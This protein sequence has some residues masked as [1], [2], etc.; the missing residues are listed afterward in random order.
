MSGRKRSGSLADAYERMQKLRDAEAARERGA[1]TA[2]RV[3]EQFQKLRDAAPPP[4]P[5]AVVELQLEAYLR[6]D[7]P[8]DVLA[9]VARQLEAFRFEDPRNPAAA[10]VDREI[11]RAVEEYENAQ[12]EREIDQA[13]EDRRRRKKKRKPRRRRVTVYIDG[14][15]YERARGCV[16]HMDDIGEEPS[17]LSRLVDLAIRRELKRLALKYNDGEPFERIEESLPG[18]RPEDPLPNVWD[19]ERCK[20]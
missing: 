7:P 20:R 11:R 3:E 10:E 18:G 14:E 16:V 1:E 15:E 12:I 17:N 5:G 9:F 6:T 2:S 13:E 19:D 8:S 4:S